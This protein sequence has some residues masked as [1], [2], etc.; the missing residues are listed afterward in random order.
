MLCLL[1]SQ[2]VVTDTS[3]FF[4]PKTQKGIIVYS[5]AGVG[6][7]RLDFTLQKSTDKGV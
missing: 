6:E 5:E 7:G 2:F 4:A 1:I 3:G